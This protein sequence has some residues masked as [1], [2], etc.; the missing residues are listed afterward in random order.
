M[1]KLLISV[2]LILLSL[3]INAAISQSGITNLKQ[4]DKNG[5]IDLVNGNQ[6][7]GFISDGPFE[8]PIKQTY[9]KDGRYETI[10][11]DR[12]FKGKWRAEGESYATPQGKKMCTKNN[13]ATDWSCFYWYTG[14]KDGGT[15]AYIIAQGQIF[16]QYHEI[17]S[18]VQIKAEAKKEAQR[19]KVADAKKAEEKKKAAEQKR[20]ADAKK[21][22][23]KKKAAEQKRLADAKKAERIA[24][25]KLAEE[26]K[27]AEQK[28][29]KEEKRIAKENKKLA[30]LS[31][32]TE[33]QNA[34]DFLSDIQDYIKNNPD[35]F[36]FFEIVKFTKNTKLIAEGIL[37]DEQLKSIGLF[38]EFVK[39]STTF[40]EF[41]KNRQNNRKISELAKIDELIDN[42]NN[43]FLKIKS[44]SKENLSSTTVNL[45]D[46]KIKLSELI[47]NNPKTFAELEN[48][49]EDLRLFL[50]DL[51]REAEKSI[52]TR[53]ENKKISKEFN[54]ELLKIDENINNLKTY[55]VE[56]IDTI[57]TELSD[58]ILDKVTLLENT[59]QSISTDNKRE[60]LIELL[61]VNK[62]ISSFKLD[63]NFL[64]SDE[65]AAI[66]KAAADKKKVDAKK[67]ADKKKEEERKRKAE[68][69]RKADAKERER[70][71][72]FKEIF[73]TCGHTLNEY[74]EIQWAFDGK[75]IY[76]DGLPL[77]I[78]KTPNPID[79]NFYWFVEKLSLY[80]YKVSMLTMF[81]MQLFTIDFEN[82]KSRFEHD[83]FGV[84]EYAY[85]Y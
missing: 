75:I 50:S 23:E 68:E 31:P 9:F 34:Q 84:R 6:L 2:A 72:N 55:Y 35:E 36:D 80:K 20:V 3:N 22:E 12:V 21:A 7:T 48:T 66:K 14:N 74:F 30:L 28:R 62:E 78:G 57:S 18:V 67:I 33:F 81:G 27:A 39:L 54:A 32:Q 16:H 25:E 29:V 71:K 60:A 61:K 43:Y 1:K 26:K 45:L 53:D 42:V 19:K 47:I 17:K 10:Y 11:E 51:R 59:K 85:C 44:F 83:L 4:L 56:N 82:Y 41:Q 64:T 8:G 46:Q 70:L 63:N 24:Q 52:S 38:K 69:K 76:I 5:I 73:M 49:K 79:N 40:L 37:D 58:L 65:V 13:N 77:K 15:Y